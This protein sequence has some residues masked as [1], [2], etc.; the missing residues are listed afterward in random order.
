[1][2][3]QLRTE[4]PQQRPG[5][6]LTLTLAVLVAASFA[7]SAAAAPPVYQGTFTTAELCSPRGV[8]LMPTGD[9]LVGSDCL[10]PHLQR[11][12]PTGGS[13]GM[14]TFPDGYLGSP[15]GLAVDGPGN[16]FVTDYAGNRVYKFTTG[17]A[18][19][20]WATTEGP[21]DVAV[22]GSGDVFVVGLHGRRVQKFTNGG[23]LV[24]SF[25]TPGSGPGQFLDPNGLAVDA[26]G[27]VYVVDGGRVR[28]LRFLADGSFDMEFTPPGVA[29][30]P[31][32]VAVGPDGNLYVVRFDANQV[33]QYSPGGALLA[34]F[35]SPN[36]LS[37]AYRI[38]ISPTGAMYV[39][40]QYN[41]RVTKFQMDIVTHA[42]R[43]TFGRLKA[44]YR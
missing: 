24:S 23:S 38:A 42:A 39:S 1:M 17:G 21:A 15:N 40:E 8:D 2:R 5:R 30:S 41:H 6:R 16:I 4:R 33:H 25:G 18:I 9:V 43:T 31:T 14:W 26:S 37:G 35:G 10:D 34:S 12:T 20:S 19:V 32:D 7:R 13:L 27:R 22:N 3:R 28:I 29:G 11:F 44:L 36:G